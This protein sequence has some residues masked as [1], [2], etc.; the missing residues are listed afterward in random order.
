M[1]LSCL[2]PFYK[3]LRWRTEEKEQMKG[4]LRTCPSNDPIR[5]GPC[6]VRGPTRDPA[7]GTA[8]VPLILVGSDSA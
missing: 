6:Q 4:L 3:Y 5:D 1:S 2:N 8:R 7:G